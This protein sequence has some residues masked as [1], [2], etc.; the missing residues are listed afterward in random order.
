MA[1]TV[2]NAS[3]EQLL[4]E[5]DEIVDLLNQLDSKLVQAVTKAEYMDLKSVSQGLAFALREQR[6]ARNNVMSEAGFLRQRS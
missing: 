2:V 5:I 3:S 6:A 1:E 4:Q